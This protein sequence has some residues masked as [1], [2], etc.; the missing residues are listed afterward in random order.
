MAELLLPHGGWKPRPYQQPLWDFLEKGGRRAIAICHRRRGKDDVALHWSAVSAMQ[1][2]SM[3]WHMLPEAA[4]ARK[5][6]W[7]AVNPHTGKRRIDEAFPQ[8]IRDTTN[9]QEMFI[10]FKNGSTWQVIGSDN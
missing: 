3:L 2:P 1:R 9:E 8:A 10:R 7:L 5:A 6:I 4:Q